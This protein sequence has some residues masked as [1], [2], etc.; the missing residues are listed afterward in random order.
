[1]AIKFLKKLNDISFAYNDNVVRFKSDSLT[2]NPIA[3]LQIEGIEK[4]I[5][6]SPDNET[7]EFS[8]NFKT[9]IPSLINENNFEHKALSKDLFKYN[10]DDWVLINLY[11]IVGDSSDQDQDKYKTC[12]FFLKAAYSIDELKRCK[13]VINQAENLYFYPLMPF[14]VERK[15]TIKI[16]DDNFK[17]YLK[18]IIPN[19][20][21]NDLMEINHQDVKNLKKINVSRRN[22]KSLQ[23]IEYF[24]ALIYLNCYDCSLT[25]LDL[26]NNTALIYLNL[27]YCGLT[28]LDLSNNTALTI[29][30]V[31]GNKLTS[32]DLSNNP[33]LNSRNV[34]ADSSTKITW[35]IDKRKKAKASEKTRLKNVEIKNTLIFYS[36]I[37]YFKGY[38]LELP[39]LC[40]SNIKIFFSDENFGNNNVILPTGEDINEGIN[41]YSVQED[42]VKEGLNAIDFYSTTD[43]FNY[44]IFNLH[45]KNPLNC[46]GV[47][48]KWFNGYGG[49][50]YH[51][52]ERW[53]SKQK[54]KSK[55]KLTR[56]YVDVL[57]HDKE[58]EMGMTSQDN[59]TAYTQ[60]EEY[61]KKIIDT[62]F[63]S[64]KIYLYLKKANEFDSNNYL[65]NWQS[66]RLGTT[67]VELLNNKDNIY[68]VKINVIKPPKDVLI[69]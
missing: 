45:S 50:S 12:H 8:F 10:V 29:L 28:V 25:V 1:M 16:P 58:L 6:L 23:G 20:F 42:K 35:Y 57:G 40:K 46:N 48:L 36:E 65:D 49:W 59:I 43:K 52:F 44:I 32:L 18:S 9:I 67:N 14:I 30:Y 21:I 15:K 61:Q 7:G 63:A 39:F 4:I 13:S 56:N 55:G 5:I 31:V 17:A 38:P 34:Y 69:L 2:N 68:K 47:Y 19:S 33:G 24:T 51:L 60:V 37:D 27:S 26:T 66:V 22:I 53:E 41:Y 62:L 3:R 64:P 54:L 11:Y